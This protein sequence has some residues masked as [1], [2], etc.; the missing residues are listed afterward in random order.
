MGFSRCRM[1]RQVTDR[2]GQRV[3]ETWEAIYLF[4]VKFMAFT[5]V[6]TWL[7]FGIIAHE[8]WQSHRQVTQ[9]P[10]KVIGRTEK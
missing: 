3:M 1:V 10:A 8:I 2:P 4:M 5:G 9:R 7:L 6:A